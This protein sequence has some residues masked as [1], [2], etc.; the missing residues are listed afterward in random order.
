MASLSLD[1]INYIADEYWKTDKCPIISLARPLHAI[2]LTHKPCKI[3]SD[4]DSIKSFYRMECLSYAALD[5]S[6]SITGAQNPRSSREISSYSDSPFVLKKTAQEDPSDRIL[7]TSADSN[8][9]VNQITTD[10]STSNGLSSAPSPPINHLIDN[11][12]HAN[13]PPLILSSQAFNSAT[14]R[15]SLLPGSSLEKF[16]PILEIVSSLVEK[17]AITTA[18]DTKSTS[19]TTPESKAFQTEMSRAASETSPL[20]PSQSFKTFIG[21]DFSSSMG[22]SND[23]PTPL[24]V[25]DANWSEFDDVA[26]SWEWSMLK[27]IDRQ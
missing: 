8:I 7:S 14:T 15:K 18:L 27:E 23:F 19:P 17:S 20:K 24:V 21:N 12:N 3:S 26:E 2:D 22:L 1:R 4:S 10:S 25:S 13:S 9:C 5:H 6:K 11:E 16:S